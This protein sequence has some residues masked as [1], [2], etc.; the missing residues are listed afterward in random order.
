M[1]ANITSFQEV[2][3]A[4]CV[5]NLDSVSLNVASRSCVSLSFMSPRVTSP[6]AAS[7]DENLCSESWSLS[8]SCAS[9]WVQDDRRIKVWIEAWIEELLL[10]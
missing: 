4:T 9:E 6:H 10:L 8:G 5:Y 3:K 1:A 7:F 2:A